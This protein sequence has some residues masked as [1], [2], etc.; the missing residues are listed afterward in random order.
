VFRD[1][2]LRVVHLCESFWTAPPTDCTI[3]SR[4]GTL[5]HELSHFTA[6]AGTKDIRY[7]ADP[8]R[9]LAINS[10]AG[11]VANADSHEFFAESCP[12]PLATTVA[13]TTVAPIATATPTPTSIIK[14]GPKPQPKKKTKKKPKKKV[15]KK[16][17]KA[18]PK[19]QPAKKDAKNV[20]GG[21]GKK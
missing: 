11:A 20:K 8:D 12:V 10:P 14:P 2:P 18:A 19:K 13:P 5:I 15:V 7:G 16:P 1:D 9:Q 6:V 17:K 3:D 21:K 4:P